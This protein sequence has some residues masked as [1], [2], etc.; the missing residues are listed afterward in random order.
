V[1][2]TGKS[3]ESGLSSIPPEASMSQPG[4]PAEVRS[5]SRRLPGQSAGAFAAIRRIGCACTPGR[6]AF[7][8]ARPKRSTRPTAI[9]PGCVSVFNVEAATDFFPYF[10]Q[11]CQSPV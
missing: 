3:I 1:H 6:F 4:I 9:Q 5:R 2:G 11:P 7:A 8:D 10:V